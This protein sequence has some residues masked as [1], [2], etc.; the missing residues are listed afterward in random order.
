MPMIRY[1]TVTQTQEVK[2]T[3]NSLPDAVEI[4]SAHF[5]G[6][7]PKPDVYGSVTSPAKVVGMTVREGR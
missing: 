1:Y 7:T 2:V 6:D 3:A 5:E 4:A